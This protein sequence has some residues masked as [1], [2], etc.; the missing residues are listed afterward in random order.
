M[1]SRAP[2][3]SCVDHRGGAFELQPQ[4]GERRAQLVRRVAGERPLLVDQTGDALGHRVERAGEA[5]HLGRARFLV[6]AFARSRPRRGR[7]VLRCRRR[8]GEVIRVGDEQ[9][10]ERGADQRDEPDQEQAAG[11][12]VRA[13][14]DDL[15][16][17]RDAHRAR[18]CRVPESTG[19]ATY[20]RLPPASAE[21]RSPAA[22]IAGERRADLGPV[23]EV[24]AGRVGGV[25]GRR[26]S[27]PSAVDDH[28]ARA[29]ASGVDVEG[30]AAGRRP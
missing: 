9:R 4:R 11:L 26:T 19:T 5:A 24:L 16:G 28:H 17:E 29:V 18:R 27:T 21:L 12:L 15:G 22:G 10:G 2:S 7:S 23:G 20:T 6:G 30:L 1:R 8:N 13:L 14:V 3:G 25:A